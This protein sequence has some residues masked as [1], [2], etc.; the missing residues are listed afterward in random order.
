MGILANAL[1]QFITDNII[2]GR[3]NTAANYRTVFGNAADAI[4]ILEGR[5]RGSKILHGYGPPDVETGENDDAYFDLA[6]KTLELKVDGEWTLMLSLLGSQGKSAYES[7]KSAGNTGSEADFVRSLRGQ[8]GSSAYELWRAAGNQGSVADYLLSLKGQNGTS[9]YQQ[10]K[11]AGNEGSTKDFLAT[12]EGQNGKDGNTMRWESYVPENEPGQDGDAWFHT[13][14][15]TKIAIYRYRAGEEVTSG[16]IVSNSSPWQLRFTSPDAGVS[17]GGPVPAAGVSSFNSRSGV[18]LLE[19]EDLLAHL[20]AGANVTITKNLSSG[21]LT[22]A[23][24]AAGGN[25]A[26]T[27]DMTKAQYDPNNDGKFGADIIAQDATHRFVTDSQMQGWDTKIDAAGLEVV[28]TTLASST[29]KS[30]NYSLGLS[31]AGNVV[32]VN[33]ATAVSVVVP[34]NSSVPFPLGTLITILQTGNAQV[35]IAPANGT[36][37]I[38]QADNQYKTAKKYASVTLFKI[39]M[40]EWVLNGYT[41]V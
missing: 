1:R 8:S 9:A 36:V 21:K 3:K 41:F 40:N 18:V 31:D 19:A 12:M 28:R 23:C 24:T 10:W 6:S 5:A 37:L 14:S 29:E 4:A 39:G 13:I 33:S 34:L 17:S 20:E 22:V 27:G 15:A 2:S 16:G 35:T 25:G 32:P 26:G 30:G 7:W 11:D 38:R